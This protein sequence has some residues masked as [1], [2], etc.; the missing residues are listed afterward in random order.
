[1][2]RYNPYFTFQRLSAMRNLALKKVIEAAL[3]N[4]EL[5]FQ[6]AKRYKN[7]NHLVIFIIQIKE[8]AKR[9]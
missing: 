3:N 4:Y 5:A 8:K 1:M 2:T 7:Y 6:S 9:K